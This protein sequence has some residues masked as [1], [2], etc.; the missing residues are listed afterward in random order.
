M[1]LCN[2]DNSNNFRDKSNTYVYK[3]GLPQKHFIPF[4]QQVTM[5]LKMHLKTG[6]GM[7]GMHYVVN[8]Y[9][10]LACNEARWVWPSQIMKFGQKNVMW[11]KLNWKKNVQ[12]IK[13]YSMFL[14]YDYFLKW[15]FT[16]SRFAKSYILNIVRFQNVIFLSKDK[17]N[18]KLVFQLHHFTDYISKE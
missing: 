5:H 11:L 17:I 2:N 10:K 14:K 8:F 16:H 12:N 4:S 15:N 1:L 6:N 3:Y 18:D 7:D 9:W 13:S